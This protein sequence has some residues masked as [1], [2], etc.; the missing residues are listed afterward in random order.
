[1]D[2][3][4]LKKWL[5][6]IAFFV[7]IAFAGL[8][9][10]GIIDTTGFVM[11]NFTKPVFFIIPLCF[12]VAV[13][14]LY[15][16]YM[17]VEKGEALRIIANILACVLVF[18]GVSV[19]TVSK[20]SD[21]INRYR[22]I[23]LDSS[24]YQIVN[25]IFEDST[26]E[27]DSSFSNPIYNSIDKMLI[28]ES[29]YEYYNVVGRDDIHCSANV[30]CVDNYILGFNRISKKMNNHIDNI[31]ERNRNYELLVENTGSGE[32][33]GIYYKWSYGEFDI[34]YTSRY[35]TDLSVMLTFDNSAYV[36][37][38]SVAGNE[39]FHIDMENEIEKIVDIIKST[40][41]FVDYVFDDSAEQQTTTESDENKTE[42]A[43]T[44]LTE[45][46]VRELFLKAHNLYVDWSSPVTK[47]L[48]TDWDKVT[49]IDGEEYFEVVP[50][51]ITSVDELKKEYG[52]YFSEEI[53][54]ENIDRYYVMHDG[55]M[56]GNAVLV[57]GGEI[58]CERY[59]L[60]VNT[61]TNTE[62]DFTITSYIGDDEQELNYR[63]KV[64]D[65]KWKFVGVFHWI[66]QFEFVLE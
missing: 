61:N 66:T 14:I 29:D 40:D 1:M 52:N 30:Y 38:V 36:V 55:K 5:K 46:E 42:E 49:V 23:E 20:R 17:F 32:I 12:I 19:V 39:R 4:Q 8:L 57:E 44:P 37:D 27:K 51:K 62:C 54:K 9:I 43:A 6:I 64:V 65:G 10:A 25:S 50:N 21:M 16:I 13:I 56:Y 28:Y 48:D 22:Y 58:P 41:I 35:I 59:K 60:T 45:K 2:R 47:Y 7:A 15:V 24:A 53:I 3:E 18:Y 63:L 33:D 11:N 31:A 26:I 34:T